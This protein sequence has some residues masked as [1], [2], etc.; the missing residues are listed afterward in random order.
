MEYAH[1]VTLVDHVARAIAEVLRE[2]K[3]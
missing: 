3:S 1:V 2:I